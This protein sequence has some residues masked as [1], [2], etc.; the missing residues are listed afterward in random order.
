MSVQR[1]D[2]RT[3]YDLWSDTYD[4][5]P[6]P[7]VG[8][9]ERVTP[10]LVEPAP[11]E[12]ILDAGCG[13]GRYFPKLLAAQ[14]RVVGLDF[15]VGMLRVARR[16]YPHVPLVLADLQRPWPFR[17]AA[18]DALLC[19]LVG[20]HLD[21]LRDVSTE[22]VRVL[23]PGSRAVFSVYHPAMAEAGKE[24]HFLRDGTDFRLGAVRHS[25]ADYRA[26]FEQAGFENITL[27]EHVGDEALAASVPPAQ[28]Y[29]GFPL[30]VVFRMT[31][32]TAR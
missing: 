26:A 18:F 29:I 14:S 28:R 15:S 30:V 27:T 10:S 32:A 5:T 1:L 12:R 9:D 22:M 31:T 6:N 25:L 21:R 11:G 3:G 24:A 8:L 7:V 13:T 19:T 2:P 16:N 17:S 20:E 4:A 23:R